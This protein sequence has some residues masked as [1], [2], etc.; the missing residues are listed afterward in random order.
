MAQRDAMVFRQVGV[1]RSASVI[2]RRRTQQSGGK[3]GASSEP[4]AAIALAY[5]IAWRNELNHLKPVSRSA[6][7]G[8]GSFSGSGARNGVAAR[9]FRAGIMLCRKLK[10][11]R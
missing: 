1:G 5:P 9:H 6:G 11:E 8:A 10:P 2:G 7:L 3:N 4:P